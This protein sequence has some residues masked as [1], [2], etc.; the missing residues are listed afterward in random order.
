MDLILVFNLG[1]G[2]AGAGEEEGKET[3]GL[4]L[5][6]CSYFIDVKED[7]KGAEL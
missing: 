4:E 1:N 7:T 3:D 2:C 6:F 5:F